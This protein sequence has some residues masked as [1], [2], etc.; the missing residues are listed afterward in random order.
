M[1]RRAAYVSYEDGWAHGMW[2]LGNS[3][4]V[5]SGYYGG[6]PQGYLKRLRALFPDKRRVLHL[7]SGRVNTAEF[8]GDTCD[9][10]AAL[11]PTF[12]ADA[13][14]LTGVPIEEYD[15]ILA[16]P[17]Y[18]AEDADHYGTPL[19]SRNKVVEVLSHRMQPGAHLAPAL[20]TIRS[21]GWRG[22]VAPS[23]LLT[24]IC[25][26]GV[27]ATR[28]LSAKPSSISIAVTFPVGPTSSAIIAV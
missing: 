7:F 6:Y 5:K 9:V 13:H 8:P 22:M 16:D 25:G 27:R 20:A 1:I 28:A 23:A 18:S 2:F 4:A 26:H 11:E 14:D 3:W 24:V 17:P 19:V 12:V 15:L 10:N 21:T